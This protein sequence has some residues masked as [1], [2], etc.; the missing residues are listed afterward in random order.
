MG[1]KTDTPIIL[2]APAWKMCGVRPTVPNRRT[3]IVHGMAD[4]R[5]P[6]T[7]SEELAGACG[8]G[9]NLLLVT[10][11]HS[12]ADSVDLIIMLAAQIVEGDEWR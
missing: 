2:L 9:G 8:I 1:L 10:D 12:L 5:V 7:D 4:E 3:S 11:D 6:Y